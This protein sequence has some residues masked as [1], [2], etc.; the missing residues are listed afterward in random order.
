MAD[1]PPKNIVTQGD[2]K[3]NTVDALSDLSL[4]TAQLSSA[5]SHLHEFASENI[6]D[7]TVKR[8]ILKQVLLIGKASQF[9]IDKLNYVKSQ[10]NVKTITSR[11]ESCKRAI[12]NL[13]NKIAT[14]AKKSRNKSYIHVDDN[15][16]AKL[17][18]SPPSTAKLPPTPVKITTRLRKDEKIYK[19]SCFRRAINSVWM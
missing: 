9:L 11:T 12:S 13:E 5:I 19:I 4:T 1:S 2:A 17:I 10:S 8:I 16:L 18:K 7:G 14:S 6:D 15:I 3:V